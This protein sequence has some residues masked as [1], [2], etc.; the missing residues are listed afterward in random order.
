VEA[1]V[2]VLMEHEGLSRDTAFTRLESTGGLEYAPRQ[3]YLDL[4][5]TDQIPPDVAVQMIVQAAQA[6]ADERDPQS[7][8]A[9]T[10]QA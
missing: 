7:V 2:K 6:I 10:T 1:R 8:A 4:L 3:D 9:A 5:T